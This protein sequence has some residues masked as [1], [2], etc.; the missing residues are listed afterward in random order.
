[1]SGVTVRLGRLVVGGVFMAF[2]ASAA[3][4]D[5]GGNYGITLGSDLMGVATMNSAIGAGVSHGRQRSGPGMRSEM[6]RSLRA[7]A[8]RRGAATSTRAAVATTFRPDPAVSIRVRRQFLA[9]VAKTSGAEAAAQLEKVYAHADPLTTWSRA[10]AP[11]GMRLGD[12]GDA[13]AEY[14]T[15]NW[16]MANRAADARPAAVQAVRRQVAI[17]LANNP[18]YDR[19][20]AA[21]RQEMAEVLIYNGLLQASIYQDATQR[22]DEGLLRR[23]SDAAVARFR[24]EAHLDLRALT[25]DEDGLARRS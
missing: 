19:L 17:A 8:A 1:M 24:N 7:R 21:G 6:E 22:R 23:V 10:A 11:D 20:G 3:A 13:M 2:S 4:Q 14:W 18:A 15:V 9:F 12:V 5:F 16:V 25:L